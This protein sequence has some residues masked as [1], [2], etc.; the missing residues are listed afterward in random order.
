MKTS[1]NSQKYL[2][3]NDAQDEKMMFCVNKI[4]NALSQKNIDALETYLIEILKLNDENCI[5]YLLEMFDDEYHD[6]VFM[7]SILHVIESFNDTLYVNKVLPNVVSLYEHSPEWSEILLTRIR[8]NESTL[9]VFMS[10][11][12]EMDLDTQKCVNDIFLNL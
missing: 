10:H 5:P 2:V 12:E 3:N 11:L 1:E 6:D 4:K 7:F 8:N 9:F